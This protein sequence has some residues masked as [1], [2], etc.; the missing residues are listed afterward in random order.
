MSAL[1]VSCQ[2]EDKDIYTRLLKVRSV[3]EG[4]T[5]VVDGFKL[6]KTPMTISVETNETGNFVRKTVV[7]AIP[8]DDGMHTHIKTF[9]AYLAATPEKSVVPESVTFY[10]E[11]N[12]SD[13]ESVVLDSEDE[14]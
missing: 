6:G 14:D 10:M 11:R 8:R 9:P 13:P 12:P 3:P 4:A 2:T 7:T 1:L 5:V